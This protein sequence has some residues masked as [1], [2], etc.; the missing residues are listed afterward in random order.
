[1]ALTKKINGVEVAL[2]AQEEAALRAEW[3]QASAAAENR[4]NEDQ[5]KKQDA[6]GYAATLEAAT[7]LTIDQIRQ[8]INLG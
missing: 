6:Q 2:S 3:A 1:M 5:Q 4:R 7:G 8:A